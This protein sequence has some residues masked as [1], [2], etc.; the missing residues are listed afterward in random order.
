M[1]IQPVF[2]TIN[3]V[4]L[5]LL[6]GGLLLASCG[7]ESQPAEQTPA[8]TVGSTEAEAPAEPEDYPTAIVTKFDFEHFGSYDLSAWTAKPPKAE[9]GGDVEI[10][11]LTY[12]KDGLKIEIE[13]LDKGEYGYEVWYRLTGADGKVQKLRTLEFTNEPY[14]ITETVND[15]TVKPAKKYSRTQQV[16]KHYSQMNPLPTSATGTWKEGPA[17]EL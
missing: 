9:G 3:K 15:Y 5:A 2:S 8:E 4:A 10:E 17:D 11:V 13:E 14:A 12:E 6:L 7:S 16:D 1:K